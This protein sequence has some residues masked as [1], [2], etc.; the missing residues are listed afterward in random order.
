MNDL[1]PGVAGCLRSLDTDDVVQI[2]PRAPFGG[3][4]DFVNRV[5]TEIW[6]SCQKKETLNLIHN[7]SCANIV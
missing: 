4:V 3:W 6:G 5:D 1:D 2:I 7:D